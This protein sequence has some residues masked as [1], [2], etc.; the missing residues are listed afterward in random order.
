M[1]LNTSRSTGSYPTI[2]QIP[3]ISTS[4][5]R[6]RPRRRLLEVDSLANEVHGLRLRL[7]VRAD[8]ELC[9]KPEEDEVESDREEEDADEER[10]LPVDVDV[11]EKALVGSPGDE[12]GAHDAEH[13]PGSAEDV[14]RLR[15]PHGEELDGQEVEDHLERSAEAVLAPTGNPGV[16]SDGHL[17]DPSTGHLRERRKK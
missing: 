9:E 16:M 15:R 6:L 8:D 10:G 11:V 13:E 2:P 3:H 1:R 12:E 14:A 4:G 7:V 5:S 17:G